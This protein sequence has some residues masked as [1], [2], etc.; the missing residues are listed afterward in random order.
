MEVLEERGPVR[1]CPARFASGTLFFFSFLSYEGPYPAFFI[2][3]VFLC[4]KLRRVLSAATADRSSLTDRPLVPLRSI[5]FCI[6]HPASS[7]VLLP[8]PSIHRIHPSVQSSTPTPQTLARTYAPMSL[9]STAIIPTSASPGDREKK[10][11][12][13]YDST[14][15]LHGLTTAVVERRV[16]RFL[17]CLIF[18]CFLSFFLCNARRSTAKLTHYYCLVAAVRWSCLCCCMDSCDI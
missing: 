3:C 4:A 18:F 15:I 10:D 12:R 14:S 11:L 2:L 6:P 1:G 16:Y 9:C 5:L 7:F 13:L 17:F 8:H